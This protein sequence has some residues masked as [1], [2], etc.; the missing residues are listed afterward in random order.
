MRILKTEKIIFMKLQI[1]FLVILIFRNFIKRTSQL[2]SYRLLTRANRK[3]EI[4]NSQ[5]VVDILSKME[6]APKVRKIL[7]DIISL[8][9]I[10]L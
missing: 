8:I 9:F 5:I 4:N 7:L 2:T 10:K 6:I 3:I 1:I